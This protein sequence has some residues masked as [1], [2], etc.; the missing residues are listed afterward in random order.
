MLYYKD[1]LFI[2]A[3]EDLLTEIPKGCHHFK[4]AGDFG[5]EKKIELVTRNL[6]WENLTDWIND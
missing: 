6:Y 3:N 5:Q 2:P 4:V 1:K